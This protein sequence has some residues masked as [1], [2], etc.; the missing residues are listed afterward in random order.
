MRRNPSLLRQRNPDAFI[1]VQHKI[2]NHRP[3]AFAANGWHEYK[4]GF[5]AYDGPEYWAGLDFLH[6]V[7][8]G[9]KYTLV[10]AYCFTGY[11]H[12]W[13]Y[14]RSY[15]VA[16]EALGYRHSGWL[17]SDRNVLERKYG[18]KRHYLIPGTTFSTRDH[19][20]AGSERGSACAQEDGGGWWLTSASGAFVR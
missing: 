14:Y 1:V 8:A 9:A 16:G 11:G 15:K 7:T 20:G 10:T 5:G 17:S 19:S 2:Q 12:S 6:N 18:D 13:R 3:S 4:R